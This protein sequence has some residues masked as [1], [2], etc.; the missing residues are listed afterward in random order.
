MVFFGLAVEVAEQEVQ[1]QMLHHLFHHHLVVML[2]EDN[3]FQQLQVD[4]VHQM[5]LQDQ[6]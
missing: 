2:M 6:M 1:D 4:L 3:V 5:I